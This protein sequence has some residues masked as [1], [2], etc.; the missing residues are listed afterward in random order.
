MIGAICSI[1]VGGL[2]EAAV[3]AILQ[4]L[5]LP[6]VDQ[7]LSNVFAEVFK[8]LPK[9]E[10]NV[11]GFNADALKAALNDKSDQLEADLTARVKQ[12]AQPLV[13]PK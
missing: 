10:F 4:A 3:N 2:I 9:L 7:L 11:P 1:D 6:T 13:D 5:N 12:L 8:F